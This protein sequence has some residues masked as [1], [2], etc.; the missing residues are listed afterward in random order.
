MEHQ[1]F[2]GFD[3]GLF[4]D[5]FPIT[6][7][8][9]RYDD[10]FH[11][12]PL[13]LEQ[14]DLGW[15][16]PDPSLSME[17]SLGPNHQV[18]FRDAFHNF[19]NTTAPLSSEGTLTRDD[20]GGENSRPHHAYQE[21]AEP[22]VPVP[23][24][25]NK[26]KKRK[27]CL[28]PVIPDLHEKIEMENSF[29]VFSSTS[30]TEIQQR[31]RKCFSQN[32][33]DH[34]AF[35]RRIGACVQCKLH[36][37]PCSF[38]M[39]CDHCFKRAGDIALGEQICSRRNLVA[40]RFDQFDLLSI[41]KSQQRMRR[42]NNLAVVGRRDLYLTY[43]R[44]SLG[45]GFQPANAYI[46]LPIVSFDESNYVGDEL[47]SFWSYWGVT[48]QPIPDPPIAI[49]AD[50][51]PTTQKFVE[52]YDASFGMRLGSGPFKH[53]QK[54]IQVFVDLYCARNKKLPLQSLVKSVF[55]LQ[56]LYSLYRTAVRIMDSPASKTSQFESSY[57]KLQIRTTIA[58]DIP[59]LEA[60]IFTYKEHMIS[61]A[62]YVQEARLK[63]DLSRHMYNTLTSIYSALY[64]VSSPL[65]LDWR[66]EAVSEMLGRD[67]ELI[68]AFCDIKTE[69]YW[70]QSEMH[71]FIPEDK[72]FRTLVV[73]NENR[74]LEA[75][76]NAARKQKN[77]RKGT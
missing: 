39:P 66:N 14:D 1:D 34:V 8:S 2:F 67:P 35:L 44:S 17:I 70:I 45:E 38:G 40:T 46:K 54:F 30:G 36:K 22:K 19:E 64:K 76:K 10:L 31:K 47:V 75:H 55:H 42:L 74:L 56:K 52:A 59:T 41:R 11:F 5:N 68:R 27:T 21:V 24:K 73:E 57:I 16:L 69:M 28:D 43:D 58:K 32:K 65:T 61:T 20:Q 4:D 7:N 63:Y 77:S 23:A 29:K 49:V 26:N 25:Q 51:L 18:G 48:N 53:L 72:L 13:D 33:K 12:E 37:V 9:L 15:G 6:S 50:S 62:Y 60:L 3:Y 71:F